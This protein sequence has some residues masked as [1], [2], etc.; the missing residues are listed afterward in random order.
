MLYSKDKKAKARIIQRNEYRYSTK[1]KLM[2]KKI[3]VEAMSFAPLQNGPGAHPVSSTM[4]TGC[5]PG[6]NPARAWR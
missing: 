1:K 3:Q 5:L 4:G 6:V 2:E